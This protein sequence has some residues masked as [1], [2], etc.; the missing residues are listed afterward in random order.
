MKF[1][2]IVGLVFLIVLGL[3]LLPAVLEI[4]L[5]FFIAALVIT[6]VI[7]IL[8]IPFGLVFLFWLWFYNK[9]TTPT[10]A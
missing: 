5:G 7:G 10:P 6:T 9:I 3:S 4:V 2:E 1:L 8:S